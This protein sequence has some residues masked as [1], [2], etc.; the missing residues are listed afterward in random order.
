MKK[1]VKKLIMLV[2]RIPIMRRIAFA[3]HN[4]FPGLWARIRVKIMGSKTCPYLIP[5]MVQ[6]ING[7]NFRVWIDFSESSKLPFVTGIQRVVH[8]IVAELK[9]LALDLELNLS[10]EHSTLNQPE[11][12]EPIQFQPQDVL[13]MLDSSWLSILEGNFDTIFKEFHKKNA[14]IFTVIYDLNPIDFPSYFTK[15]FTAIFKCWL[16]RAI[17][18]SDGFICISKTVA[19][20]LKLYLDNSNYN[21]NN[22]NNNKSKYINYWH[23]GSNISTTSV[24]HYLNHH[25]ERLNFF[26]SH[27]VSHLTTF[28]TVGTLEPRKGHALILDAFE[29]LWK[30]GY[31]IRLCIA[32]KYG[33]MMQDLIH[34]IEIHP[35]NGSRLIFISQPTDAELVY[36]YQKSNALI[37]ASEAEGFGLP[38]VE[39]SRFGIPIFA[40][41]IEVF[42]EIGE[43]HISYF[44]VGD[45]NSLESTIENWLIDSNNS[46]NSNN[47]Q[48]PDS[49]KIKSLTWAESAVE[50][51][52]IIKVCNTV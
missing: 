26:S 31:A 18:E 10:L 24:N 45:V 40:S 7:S 35:E 1:I 44:K 48:R 33:W 12:P 28:I 27:R 6:D 52:N 2:K 41:D 42:R 4:A 20:R 38:I 23:L 17:K 9:N 15:D 29:L 46:N 34:R 11:V 3:V 5:V 19:E 36:C 25:S 32:G 22:N 51:L 16:A 43:D 39:A 13:L 14:K 50:L 37:I 21:N 47:S 30:K 49:K 8:N